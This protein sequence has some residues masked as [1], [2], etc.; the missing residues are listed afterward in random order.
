[1]DHLHRPER[2]RMVLRA[3]AAHARLGV[4]A[5]VPAELSA[6]RRAAVDAVSAIAMCIGTV[7]LMALGV[8]Y[9]TDRFP[10]GAGSRRG[11]ARRGGHLQSGS[12]SRQ[13]VKSRR[14]LSPA[15]RRPAGRFNM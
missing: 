15:A 7:G 14:S 12:S 13:R 9:C 3:R 6:A 2:Q 5:G 8:E 1:M 4:R 10:R 11:R